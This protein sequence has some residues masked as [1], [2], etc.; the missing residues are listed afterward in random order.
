MDPDIRWHGTIYFRK[1]EFREPSRFLSSCSV[2]FRAFCGSAFSE[3]TTENTENENPNKKKTLA[4][5]RLNMSLD[6]PE[7][8]VDLT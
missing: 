3:I 5:L 7:L 6:E 4:F 8:F 1:A 2:L